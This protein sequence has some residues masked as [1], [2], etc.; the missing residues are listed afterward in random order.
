M[1]KVTRTALWVWQLQILVADV[2]E[3]D[4]VQAF[5][6]ELE[7]KA[8]VCYEVLVHSAEEKNIICEINCVDYDKD[9]ENELPGMLIY[10]VRSGDTLW[11][12][13]KTYRIP[14]EEIKRENELNSELLSPGQKLLLIR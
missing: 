4:R 12:I 9:Q 14:T 1:R 5:M 7:I 10:F 8:N 13:G 11:D 6:K 2:S 3:F